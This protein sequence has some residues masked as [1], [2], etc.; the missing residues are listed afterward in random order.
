MSEDKKDNLLLYELN[1]S[2]T[3]FCQKT[4]VIYMN[5]KYDHSQKY[6]G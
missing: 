5:E 1:F 2:L 3:F 6:S 4:I